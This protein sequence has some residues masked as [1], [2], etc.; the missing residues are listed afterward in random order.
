MS[1][2]IETDVCDHPNWEE[3]KTSDII[4][5]LIKKD[6]HVRT[7]ESCT[8]CGIVNAFTNVD[9]SSKIIDFAALTYSPEVKQ[10]ILGVPEEW[11]TD[12]NIVS[13]ETSE[14]MNEGLVKFCHQFPKKSKCAVIYVTITGWIGSCPCNEDGV[15]D[16]AFFTLYNSGTGKV[17]TYRLNV[18]KGSNKA[19][20]KLLIIHRI[21][22]E[23]M[24]MI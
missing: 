12:E 1:S 17:Q 15:G 3:M 11:T 14:F 9:G 5:F 4:T 21:L 19:E 22:L 24:S 20:K 13:R 7:A 18:N 8:G 16:E 23:I 10:V 6:V 2:L